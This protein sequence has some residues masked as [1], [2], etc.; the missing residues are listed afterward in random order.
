MELNFL[1]RDFFLEFKDLWLKLHRNPSPTQRE[2]FNAPAA[3]AQQRERCFGRPS[4]LSAF[5]LKAV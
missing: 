3:A 5:L 2:P 1:L 4:F